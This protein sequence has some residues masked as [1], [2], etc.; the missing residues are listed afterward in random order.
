[1]DDLRVQDPFAIEPMKSFFRVMFQPGRGK[2]A[3]QAPQIK[4]DVHEDDA[5]YTVKV[6]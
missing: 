5:A 2:L 1:M 4:I 6:E 3:R